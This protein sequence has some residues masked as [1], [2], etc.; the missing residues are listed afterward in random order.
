MPSAETRLQRGS[1]A[2]AI[3]FNIG[4]AQEAI[5]R[6]TSTGRVPLHEDR[7]HFERLADLLFEAEQGFE[8][9]KS[10][11]EGRPT[12]LTS[13]ISRYLRSF[14]IVLPAIRSEV[15]EGGPEPIFERLR[16]ALD[17][18]AGGEGLTVEE[19][20]LLLTVLNR[21]STRMASQGTAAMESVPQIGAFS[22]LP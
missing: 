1:Q 8:W 5:Y 2:L 13:E 10:T 19:R 17:L 12:P 18:V 20:Q 3:A 21:L 22:K 7:Q 11:M 9:I 15:S 4:R 16:S 6:S 14:G